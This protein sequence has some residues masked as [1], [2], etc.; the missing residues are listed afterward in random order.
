MKIDWLS[1][2]IV[3]SF[4]LVNN[5][6]IIELPTIFLKKNRLPI[7]KFA[8]QKVDSICL[9]HPIYSWRHYHRGGRT[10]PTTK[11][12]ANSR[13]PKSSTPRRHVSTIPPE[14][15]INELRKLFIDRKTRLR[16][17]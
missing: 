10:R 4:S 5:F 3:K 7:K 13:T 11:L 12:T 15:A 14:R 17:L 6:Q 16:R 8:R 2:L 1:N 9:E